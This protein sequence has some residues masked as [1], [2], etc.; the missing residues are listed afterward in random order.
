MKLNE[1]IYEYRKINNWSQ[2]ELADKLD[3]SRQTI[4]KWENGKASPELEKLMALADLFKV[5]VDAL[6]KEDIDINKVNRNESPN[7]Q[8]NKIYKFFKDKNS[9]IKKLIIAILISIT[10]IVSYN[11]ISAKIH[12]LKREKDIKEVI[13]SYKEL[14]TKDGCFS[15]KESYSKKENDRIIETNRQYYMYFEDGKELVKVTEYDG[16]NSEKIKKQIYIDLSNKNKYNYDW[17]TN[18][19]TYNQV[20]E[21]Y[22][23]DWSHKVMD[24][25]VFVSPLDK[26]R[27]AL[28]ERYFN[29]ANP[30]KIIAENPENTIIALKLPKYNI[31]SYDWNF[32]DRDNLEKEDVLSMHIEANSYWMA[33]Y[34]DDYKN[35]I[36]ETRE[37]ISIQL[38]KIKGNIDDVTIPEL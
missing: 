30:A 31:Q 27:N 17:K 22:I 37:I 38:S 5:S 15:I 29:K 18:A 33:F 8:L 32:G 11:I 14:V 16:D 1:K 2:E 9:F 24:N 3:V 13:N 7:E 12:L 21:V 23:D 35:D 20:V 36:A 26:M 19:Y 10:I 4:S 28:D 6:V 25:Y 34:L